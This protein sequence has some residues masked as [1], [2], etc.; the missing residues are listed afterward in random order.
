MPIEYA[1]TT[2]EQPWWDRGLLVA[3][4]D[5]AGRG[6]L[7]G[8]VVAAAVI[9]DPSNVPRGLADS[10]KLSAKLRMQMRAAVLEKALAI[11]VSIVDNTV[12]DEINI[13]QATFRAMHESLF[14][15]NALGEP[16]QLQ[17]SHVFVDGNRFLEWVRP[18]TCLV[19]GDAQ[20]A[21]IAAA[22]I[23]AKTTRDAI[24]TDDVHQRYPMYGFDNHVGYGT[25]QHRD[26]LGMFGACSVHRLTF[27][28]KL[29]P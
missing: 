15:L 25:K 10:K 17:V 9:L 16:G 29:L 5:E 1:T 4:V 26:A 28:R 6:A 27:L 12:I 21:S 7:A 3:G 20:C 22:S 23:I 24:M 2:H 13:L 11:G 14:S 18:A 8:P 19:G